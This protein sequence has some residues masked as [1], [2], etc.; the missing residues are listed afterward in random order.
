MLNS[1]PNPETPP[2]MPTDNQKTPVALVYW[3]RLGAGAALMREMAEAFAQDK[4]FELYASASLQS[5]LPPRIAADRNLSIETF[6]GPVSLAMRTLLLPLTL[7][8]L[9]ARM[10]AA[11][12]RAI[13][14][15]MPHIWG[16]ALQYAARRAGIRTI[17][18]L[19]DAEPHPG[20]RRPLFD[21]L[22]R[23][24]VRRA[25]RL[26]TFSNFVADR[27][28]GLN[29]MTE[30][31]AIRLYHPIFAFACEGKGRKAPASP[32]RL[33]FFG[34]ILPYKGVPML[35]EAFAILRAAG[36]DCELRVV[37]R[38]EID[39]PEDAMTQHG[40]TIERGWVDPAA[41][42][43]ILN[44]ADA[45]V[46][47]YL[48][49]SQS[50]VIAAAYGANLPVIAT[51]VGGLAEQIN[52]GNTGLLAKGATAQYI[53]DAIR[54]LIETPGLYATCRVGVAD[55]AATHMPN[56]FARVLGDR[57]ADIL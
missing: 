28:I 55:Y 5:E 8:R 14:T 48:E 41:I 47:P 10:K 44:W 34:R 46:L 37:G 20:E 52:D 50:G 53:A 31:R 13:V 49:A 7:Y 45:M 12:I 42:A 6:T 24:E 40:L 43:D 54:K 2:Q 15:V 38:G 57:I 4:R 39:A 33:L 21:W 56:D 16:L 18:I 29:D 30:A 25:D 17:L 26:V 11:D 9:M 22:V 3:G 32:F 36:A 19:H 51:P 1:F 35:L 27:A 23:R